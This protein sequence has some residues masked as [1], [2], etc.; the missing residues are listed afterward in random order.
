MQNEYNESEFLIETIVPKDELIVSRTDL[1]GNITYANETFAQI[2]GYTVDELIGKPHNCVRH[3]DMPKQIFEELWNSLKSNNSWEGIIKN[4]RK[5]KGFYWVY[6]QISVVK[7][8]DKIVE[9]KSIRTPISFQ[10]KIKYQKLYDEIKKETK[11]LQRK[12]IYQ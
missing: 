8:D 10:D 1:K 3:P 11:D 6:A 7:K 5:D 9:Y 4:L 12:V 2:S